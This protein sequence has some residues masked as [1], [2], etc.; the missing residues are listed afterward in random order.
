M[1]IATSGLY[2]LTV[3]A[4]MALIRPMAHILVC[5]YQYSE[6]RDFMVS[7][8]LP[9]MSMTI[10]C[11]YQAG[12]VVS[13]AISS[14]VGLLQSTRDR[15]QYD[16]AI[17]KMTSTLILPLFLTHVC[18]C[19]KPSQQNRQMASYDKPSFL[20]MGEYL[21]LSFGIRSHCLNLSQ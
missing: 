13:V 5:P 16:A 14:P 11:H 12:E 10:A 7:N 15:G 20:N 19:L 8:S 6:N 4:N 17:L 18:G 2:C 9:I 1:S 21:F 3:R